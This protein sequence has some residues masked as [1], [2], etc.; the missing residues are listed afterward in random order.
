[1][2]NV[3]T[4]SAWKPVQ[5]LGV[6]LSGPAIASI[7]HTLF[8]AILPPHFFSFFNLDPMDHST[9]DHAKMT[10]A[11]M[12]H[13]G[14]D[15]GDMDMSSCAMNMFVNADTENLCILFKG[16]RVTG[17]WS[18]VQSM[19]VIILFAMSFEA[20]REYIRRYEQTQRPITLDGRPGSPSPEMT[21][22]KD[23]RRRQMIKSLLYALQV[24]ISFMLML[25]FMTYN[26][27]IMGAVIIGSALGYYFFNS[28][29]HG[30]GSKSMACH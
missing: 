9:M 3:G 21:S 4:V 10:S 19:I 26:V 16:W 13:G 11:G 17:P 7:I 8:R 18:L 14:M 22:K 27:Y 20:I 30:V 6:F 25:V 29:P 15:H 28:D 1:M 5:V 2:R 23:R 12:D 24:G